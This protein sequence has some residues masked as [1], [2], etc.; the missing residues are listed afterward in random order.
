MVRTSDELTASQQ[1]ALEAKVIAALIYL[2]DVDQDNT[3]Q[4]EDEGITS[5]S[6][7]IENTIESND[8][9][10]D[11]VLKDDHEIEAL[12]NGSSE[13]VQGL[14]SVPVTTQSKDRK[15]EAAVEA[16]NLA[17]FWFPSD[18]HSIKYRLVNPSAQEGFEAFTEEEAEFAIDN[19]NILWSMHALGKAT[20]IINANP[21]VIYSQR[22]LYNSIQNSGG[23]CGCTGYT[24]EELQYAIYNCG[25]NWNT[26]AI[27]EMKMYW[28]G[29][30]S[31]IITSYDFYDYLSSLGYDTNTIEY[32]LNNTN[33][34][35][36][37]E[38]V[39][40][41]QERV[42]LFRSYGY[43]REAIINWYSPTMGYEAAAAFVD[44]CE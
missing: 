44:S 13:T 19:A 3:K 11:T 37:G 12:E 14:D 31:V 42:K 30:Y 9:K 38:A 43:T 15:Q 10:E 34:Y 39:A 2:P 17:N 28:D 7:T 27:N 21:G 41:E 1:K 25:I 26:Q 20:E 18:R 36:R 22:D 40:N 4:I 6:S 35:Y 23:V 5:E 32:A 16:D 33:G 24:E 8:E 29:D